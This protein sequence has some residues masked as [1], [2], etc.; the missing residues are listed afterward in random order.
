MDVNTLR[1]IITTLSFI[2]FLGI[3]YWAYSKNSKARF[4]EAAMLPFADDDEAP[5]H[6]KRAARPAR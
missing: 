6:A 3:V 5:I 4:D 1:A 2:A